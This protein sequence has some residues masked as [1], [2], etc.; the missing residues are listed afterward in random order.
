MRLAAAAAL[1]FLPFSSFADSIP[2]GFVRMS[3]VAPQIAS[4]IRYARSFNFTGSIVPGYKAAECIVTEA[5]AQALIEAETALNKQGFALILFDC[6]RP[7]RAV[8]YFV[9]WA[10]K[11]QRGPADDFFLPDLQRSAV[12]P[13]GY[14]AEE[15]AHSLGL[16][17]DVGL[18]RLSDPIMRPELVSGQRCDGPFAER[19]LESSLDMGT[20]F[21]CFSLQS[22][23]SARI[24]AVAETNRTI[25][26]EAMKNAGFEG[27][28]A[29]WWH[30]QIR[31]SSGMKA[32]DFP[33][34]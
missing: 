10:G 23:A 31:H 21:D 1:A 17:V 20:S 32:W 4:D 34:H 26:A 16:T 11:R 28:S 6:Y 13:G 33:V 30:F 27:Y 25:L 5:T 9:D 22:G 14:V 24:P 2:D 12:I 7:R 8:R 19:A 3:D 18:Q 15:S 29:E